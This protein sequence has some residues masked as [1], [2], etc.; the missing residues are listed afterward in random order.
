MREYALILYFL[1][2]SSF[3]IFL[4]INTPKQPEM[5]DKEGSELFFTFI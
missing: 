4:I 5:P 3:S 2:K 1:K